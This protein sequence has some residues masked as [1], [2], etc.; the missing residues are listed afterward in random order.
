MRLL[1]IGEFFHFLAV[2]NFKKGWGRESEDANELC[3]EVRR[4]IETV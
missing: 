2:I 4:Y 3:R 1:R